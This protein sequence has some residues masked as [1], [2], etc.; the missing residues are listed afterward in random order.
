MKPK[1]KARRWN[2][3]RCGAPL[4]KPTPDSTPAGFVH[5]LARGSDGR[6]RPRG[7]DSR[8]VASVEANWWNGGSLVLE[9]RGPWT[10]VSYTAE[11]PEEL[12]ECLALARK[13]V[14]T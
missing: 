1:E 10:F 8:A 3:G 12:A 6:M 4:E 2:G 9:R 5:V 13:A 7:L 11:S 14:R